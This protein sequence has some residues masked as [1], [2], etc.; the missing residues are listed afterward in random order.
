[1]QVAGVSPFTVP[2]KCITSVEFIST[3]SKDSDARTDDLGAMMIIKG[4]VLTALNGDPADSTRQMALWAATPAKSLDSYRNVTVTGVRG[5]IVIRDYN[6]PNAFVVDYVEDFDDSKGEGEFALIIKQKKDRI[7][8]ATVT[9]GF[10][11]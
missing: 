8:L 5:N 2:N 4:K 3:I 1:M 7:E 10:V 11:A 6:F 9:G